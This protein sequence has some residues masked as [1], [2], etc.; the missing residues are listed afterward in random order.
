MWMVNDVP[1]RH[2]EVQKE[3]EEERKT[4]GDEPR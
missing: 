4:A 1:L 2:Q 3:S